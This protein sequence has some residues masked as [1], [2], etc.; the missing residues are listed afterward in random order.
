[1]PETA[2]L[3]P[4][5][6]LSVIHRE[7]NWITRFIIWPSRRLCADASLCSAPV[8]WPI[9]DEQIL[10]KFL[11]IFFIFLLHF[12]SFPFRIQFLHLPYSSLFALYVSF[13]FKGRFKSSRFSIWKTFSCLACRSLEIS[14]WGHLELKARGISSKNARLRT[15]TGSRGHN[16][17]Q[18]CFK[19]SNSMCA[20]LWY[21]PINRENWF[22]RKK[23]RR[24]GVK[25]LTFLNQSSM[26]AAR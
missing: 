16:V 21:S 14:L 15:H 10:W 11:F 7:Q 4:H 23:I 3:S 20:V 24:F 1:M 5:C 19:E 13:L 12:L 22:V 26:W 9:A 18:T 17:C 8:C 6:S 25:N 2:K